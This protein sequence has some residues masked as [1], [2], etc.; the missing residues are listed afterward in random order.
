MQISLQMLCHQFLSCLGVL[1]SFVCVCACVSHAYIHLNIGACDSVI[2]S[3]CVIVYIHSH[4]MA[5]AFYVCI[6][7]DWN[8]IHLSPHEKKKKKKKK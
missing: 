1:L 6:N 8:G 2:L 4:A 7:V 3:A 5:S